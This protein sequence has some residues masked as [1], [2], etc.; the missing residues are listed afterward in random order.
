MTRLNLQ[1]LHQVGAGAFFTAK[2]IGQ[3]GLT[4]YQLQKLVRAGDVEQV[5]RGLYR[6]TSAEPTEH[7][8]L[9]AVATRVP[10]GVLCL[11]SALRYH[12]LGTQ[13][14]RE[15]WMAIPRKNRIP[16]L[17]NLPARFVRFDE[18][19]M[20]YG[21]EEIEI[22]GGPARITGIARTVVDC[23]RFPDLVG[24][25]AALEALEEVLVEGRASRGEIHRNAEVFDAR[26]LIEPLM[27]VLSL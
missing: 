9:A 15:V 20:S 8:T 19:G 12:E 13:M 14:P 26:L 1:D 27:E 7:Y 25:G 6:L 11:H 4:Y 10:H 24:R 2:D 21:V 5:S 16:R 17:R 18:A 22:E 3:I 23:L